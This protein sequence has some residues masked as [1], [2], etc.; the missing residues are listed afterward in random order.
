MSG[1]GG[2]DTITTG[3]GPDTV[4]G[5][6]GD[7]RITA[8]FNN[9]T[10][11]GGPGRDALFSDATGNFCGFFS[12]TVPFGNDTVN[13]RDGEADSIDCGV[14]ADRA[15]TDRIDTVANCETNDASGSGGGGGGGGGRGR[16]RADRALE[17][18]DPPDRLP[19]APDQG[20]VPGQVHD[21]GAPP[22]RQE[23]RTQAAAGALAP[24]RVRPQDAA[25]G[26][27]DDAH[28]EGREEGAQAL[29]ARAQ[30]D[31]DPAG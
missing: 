2:N 16:R 6:P 5:G 9:D 11:T 12:C 10:V 17:A 18:L 1:G 23:A 14:G 29:P 22:H 4:D 24:A 19:R 7:D 28:P 30:D 15:V 13:A 20:L 26:R 21:Q 8:G 27:D 25:V 3:N 31:R